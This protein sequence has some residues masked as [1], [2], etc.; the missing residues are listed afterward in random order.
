VERGGPEGGRDSGDAE[1]SQDGG[2]G[3]ARRSGSGMVRSTIR[4]DIR[5]RRAARVA[6]KEETMKRIEEQWLSYLAEVIPADAGETQ[7]QESRRAFY[8]G[9][10]AL[11]MLQVRLFDRLDHEPTAADLKMMDEIN[12]ELEQFNVDVLAGFA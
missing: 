3:S 1:H 11:L 5:A 8:A 9:A 6:P 10:R 12:A 7:V 2:T 4:A